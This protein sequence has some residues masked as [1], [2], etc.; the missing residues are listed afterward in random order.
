M[1]STPMWVEFIFF[2]TSPYTISNR[3]GKVI[4]QK[5][6]HEKTLLHHPSAYLHSPLSKYFFPFT[7]GSDPTFFRRILLF[8]SFV[9]R[10][11]SYASSEHLSG[12]PSPHPGGDFYHPAKRDPGGFFAAAGR[13][14]RHRGGPAVRRLLPLLIVLLWLCCPEAF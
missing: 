11:L 1:S 5:N 7:A 2:P 4:P 3:H 10:A 13:R 14:D 9:R 12:V 6:A 8:S